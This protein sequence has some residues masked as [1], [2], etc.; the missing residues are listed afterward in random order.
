MVRFMRILPVLLLGMASIALAQDN[1]AAKSTRR[2]GV[3]LELKH[4]PQAKPQEAL[5]SVL[6]AVDSGRLYY[7]A[8]HL[9]DPKYIDEW[10]RDE[11]R[12]LPKSGSEEDRNLVAFDRV[13][14]SIG[15]H[16]RDDPSLLRDLRRIG[17]EGQWEQLGPDRSAAKVK[18][19]GRRAIF[20]KVAGR[21][22][23]ENR[24]EK[25]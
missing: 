5:Q 4:Y 10:V 13:V 23:L 24:L 1:G 18:G 3:D 14:Q 19:I 6:K 21:W 11:K 15:R 7:L 2:Y 17:K 25:E 22:Y 20:R 12:D 9:A 16:L 8:A